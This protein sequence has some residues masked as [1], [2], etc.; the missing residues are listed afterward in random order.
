MQVGVFLDS[1]TLEDTAIHSFDTSGIINPIA[2]CNSE[3]DL[4]HKFD[5]MHF[6]GGIY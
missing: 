6:M 1:Q 3:G 4:N 2:Q 5:D